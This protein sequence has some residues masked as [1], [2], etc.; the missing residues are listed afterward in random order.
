MSPPPVREASS[1]AAHQSPAAATGSTAG[2]SLLSAGPLPSFTTVRVS[3]TSQITRE[4]RRRCVE[5]ITNH[6][7]TI[8]WPASPGLL[9]SRAWLLCPGVGLMLR[10]FTACTDHSLRVVLLAGISSAPT[11]QLR[12]P[13]PC[14]GTAVVVWCSGGSR[15]TFGRTRPIL[16]TSFYALSYIR[17]Y[18]LVYRASHTSDTFLRWSWD[19]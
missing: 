7:M 13:P 2:L 15:Q 10:V 6:I 14:K 16:Y 3:F 8:R 17:A 12:H 5:S 9:A 18:I 19:V 1:A 11:L 4:A